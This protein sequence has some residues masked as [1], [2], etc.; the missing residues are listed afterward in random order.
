MRGA[1][2]KK[3]GGRVA[4]V[5]SVAADARTA[6]R[7]AGG[8]DAERSGIDGVIGTAQ[9]DGNLRIRLLAAATGIDGQVR[10]VDTAGIQ[11]DV[12]CLTI[13]FGQQPLVFDVD[14]G[15]APLKSTRRR[16]GGQSLQAAENL[17]DVAEPAIGYLQRTDAIGRILHSSGEFG[18]LARVFVGHGQ[19]CR[20]VSR[21]I[22]LVTRGQLLDRRILKS[23]VLVD[24]ILR[25]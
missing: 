8:S 13:E 7:D 9:I 21:G 17:R 1:A 3:R 5:Y 14:G 18:D 4:E 10:V 2:G 6:A 25:V 11:S 23:L 12:G 19:A 20:I 24:V 22:D 16:F 15:P